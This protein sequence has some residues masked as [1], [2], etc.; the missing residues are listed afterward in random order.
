MADKT[1]QR[2][3]LNYLVAGAIMFFAGGYLVKVGQDDGGVAAI[4]V[5]AIALA[6]GIFLIAK[7]VLVGRR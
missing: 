6:T 2:S 5:G 7:G 4:V 3:E 1:Q